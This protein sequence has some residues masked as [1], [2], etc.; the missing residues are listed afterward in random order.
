MFDFLL[1]AAILAHEA[2]SRRENNLASLARLDCS[3]RKRLARPHALD[4][5]YDWYV[6]ITGEHE[7]AVHRVDGEVGVDGLLRGGEGLRNG[8]STEDSASAGRVP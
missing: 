1:A 5:V 8:C 4:V 6:G 7:V 3:C 2:H